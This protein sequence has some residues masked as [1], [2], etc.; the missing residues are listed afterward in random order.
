MGARRKPGL[1]SPANMSK[2]GLPARHSVPNQTLSIV[3]FRLPIGNLAAGSLGRP[4]SYGARV[5]VPCPDKWSRPVPSPFGTDFVGWVERSETHRPT[6]AG[7]AGFRFALPILRR[8]DFAISRH[9]LPEVCYQLPA[10]SNERAQGRPGACCTRG[11]ACNCTQQKTHTSIQ[12]QTEHSG[13]PCAMAL[14]LTSSSP[15]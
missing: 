6:N 14:R 13:L 15:W 2:R 11:L 7:I 3:N 9:E 1:A 12:V 10:L 5:R 8:Y 4:G